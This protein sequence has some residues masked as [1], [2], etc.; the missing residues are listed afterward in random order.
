MNDGTFSKIAF[1]LAA[2]IFVPALLAGGGFII[3]IFGAI[4]LFGVLFGG[5]FGLEIVKN[6]EFGA[7]SGGNVSDM[8]QDP[9]EE[10]G[11]R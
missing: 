3:A 5:K 8:V 11:R 4:V 10:W 9:D 2:I 6:R 7:K 1:G